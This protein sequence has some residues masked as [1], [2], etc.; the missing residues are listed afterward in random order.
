MD[1]GI[2]TGVLKGDYIGP[3]PQALNPKQLYYRDPLPGFALSGIWGEGPEKVQAP[4]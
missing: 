3:T 1:L 2:V 4:K